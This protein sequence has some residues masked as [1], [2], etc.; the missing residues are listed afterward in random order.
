MN[1]V[2]IFGSSILL[3]GISAVLAQQEHLQDKGKESD[4]KSVV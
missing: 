4:R 2:L 3:V 1:R